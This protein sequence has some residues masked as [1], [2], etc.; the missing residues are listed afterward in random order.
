MH[1]WMYVAR[2]HAWAHAWLDARGTCMAG[3]M[4]RGCMRGHM[5]GWMRGYMRG[6]M[7]VVRLHARA[8]AWLHARAHAWL[9]VCGAAACVAACAGTCMAGCMARLHVAKRNQAPQAGCAQPLM[10]NSNLNQSTIVSLS[11]FRGP[12]TCCPHLWGPPSLLLDLAIAG[13]LKQ[14]LRHI[15]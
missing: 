10:L 5:R 13:R 11:C 3:C 6:C 15:V 1:G 8:H 2:L 12:C 4:W 9:D 14:R 7:Y